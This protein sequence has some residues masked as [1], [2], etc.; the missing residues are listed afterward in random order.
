MLCTTLG[1]MPSSSLD[2]LL[3]PLVAETLDKLHRSFPV[4]LYLSWGAA[5]GWLDRRGDFE[6]VLRTVVVDHSGE[7]IAE[8]MVDNVAPDAEGEFVHLTDVKCF[9]GGDVIGHNK[10]RIRAS[11]ITAWA[12][13]E[14]KPTPRG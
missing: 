13:G 5:T 7:D 10:L 9:V 3:Q 4:T 14:V 11:D 6:R 1:D 8:K 12:P 2:P